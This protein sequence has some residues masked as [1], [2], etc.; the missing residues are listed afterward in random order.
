MKVVN[1]TGTMVVGLSDYTWQVQ[2]R[3]I[4]IV[5]IRDVKD[6]GDFAMYEDNEKASQVFHEML[7]AYNRWW[8]DTPKASVFYMPPYEYKNV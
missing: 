7:E 6:Y 4:C 3:K 1:Q 2:D 8:D 5:S